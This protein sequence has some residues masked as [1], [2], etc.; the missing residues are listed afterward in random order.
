MRIIGENLKKFSTVKT[1]KIRKKIPR[2]HHPFLSTTYNAAWGDCVQSTL[3]TV[4][5]MCNTRLV[6]IIVKKSNKSSNVC[7]YLMFWIK[8]RG[9]V[10]VN[11]KIIVYYETFGRVSGKL[12]FVLDPEPLLNE[13]APE[14]ALIKRFKKMLNTTIILCNRK[15][16]ILV[17][18]DSEQLKVAVAQQFWSI[19]LGKSVLKGMTVIADK[20]HIK[21]TVHRSWI[22]GEEDAI[23]TGRKSYSKDKFIN[24]VG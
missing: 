2:S 1:Q 22:K 18:N 17:K 16:S 23:M 5:C 12:I 7:N 24:D 6:A 3:C 8:K 9:K 21:V 20:K 4:S 10:E 19:K 13:A 11:V 15:L 14:I